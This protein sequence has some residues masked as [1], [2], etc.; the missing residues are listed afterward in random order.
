MTRQNSP[1]WKQISDQGLFVEIQFQI[2]HLIVVCS[3]KS[4]IC[5]V[6]SSEVDVWI[7]ITP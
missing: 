6:D 2:L 3:E 7:G 5:A 4:Q 1:S